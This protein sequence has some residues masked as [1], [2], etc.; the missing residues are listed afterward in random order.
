[1]N[2]PAG[3][4]VDSS[5]N[6]YVADTDNFVV[7]EVTIS[8][9]NIQTIVGNNTLAYSGDGAPAN[10][11]ALNF[12]GAVSA[13]AAGNIYLADTNSSVVRVV[14]TGTQPL[15]IAGV[16]IQPG[17]IQ[18]IAGNGFSCAVPAPGGCGD[19]GPSTSAQLNFPFGIFVDSSGNIFIADTGLPSTENSAIRVINPG[20]API[21]IAGVTIQPGT[22]ETV[23][24]SL[25]MAG[26]AGDGGLPTSAELFNPQGVVVDASG[27]IFIADTENSAIRVV[28]TGTQPLVIAGVTIQPNTIATVAGTPPTAC[29]DT[30]SGCGDNGPATA[31][32]LNFPAGISVDSADD[33]FIADSQSSAIR[34]VNPGTQ[35]ITDRRN[36]DRT[37]Q[38][39]DRSWHSRQR[40]LLRR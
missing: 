36:H 4:T 9:G 38:H 15:T 33:I 21:T 25:G 3:V 29:S 20:A 12:P 30:S 35:A 11:A 40:R 7:R 1:M 28:N 13:D 8:N 37:R 31:A 34:V 10:G 14:N 27:N 24:G 17:D 23:I 16:T 32:S 2:Y 19:G 18:T 6:I 5:G 22:I 26:F 39:F